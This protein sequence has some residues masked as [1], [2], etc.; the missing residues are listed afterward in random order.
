MIDH[1]TDDHILVPKLLTRCLFIYLF[2]LVPEGLHDRSP[3][4]L[5]ST[6]DV[7]DVLQVSY[8]DKLLDRYLE[9]DIVRARDS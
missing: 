5:G 8:I 1:Q 7:Q 9:Q 4:F 6:E 2:I 3:I